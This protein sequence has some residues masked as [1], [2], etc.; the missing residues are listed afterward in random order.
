MSKETDKFEK[1]FRASQKRIKQLSLAEGNKR[2]K[3][4][5]SW[6]DET[7][8]VEDAMSDAVQVARKAGVTGSKAADFIKEGNVAKALKDWKAAVAKHHANIDELTEFSG[9][10]KSLHDELLKRTTAVEKE[11]KKSKGG[12]SDVKIMATVKEAKRALADLKK[13]SGVPGTMKAHVVFYARKMQPS[14]EAIVRDALKKV[15]PKEFPKSLQEPN[16][17]KTIRQVKANERKLNALCS[18]GS[19]ALDKN[20]LKKAAGALKL[21]KKELEALEKLA[22]EYT[23]VTKKMRKE[24]KDAKDGKIIAEMIKAVL[25][26]HKKCDDVCDALDER[27]DKAEAAAT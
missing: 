24:L 21:A 13:S 23:G 5:L 16:R 1:D 4:I 19:E 7:W 25:S 3:Q 18:T 8:K 14:I 2:K 20:D 10:A 11:L 26:I 15:D 9:D 27:V 22:D 6:L 17:K 12:L